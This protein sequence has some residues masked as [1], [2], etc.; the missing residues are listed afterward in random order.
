MRRL[1]PGLIH[2][3]IVVAHRPSAAGCSESPRERGV[4]VRCACARSCVTRTERGLLLGGGGGGGGGGTRRSPSQNLQAQCL[5]ERRCYL[6]HWCVPVRAC[7]GS[8]TEGCVHKWRECARMRGCALQALALTCTLL[9]AH[10]FMYVHVCCMLYVCV[11]VHVC[12]HLSCFFKRELLAYMYVVR[13]SIC[14]CM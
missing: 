2:Q 11:R 1:R 3:T 13:P 12:T 8:C 6:R 7:A 4:C 5:C 10:M 9:I 14:A